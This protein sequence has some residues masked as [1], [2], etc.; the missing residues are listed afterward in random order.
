MTLP[1]VWFLFEHGKPV[2]WSSCAETLETTKRD[3]Q[4]M[5]RYSPH[6][7]ERCGVNEVTDQILTPDEI[8]KVMADDKLRIGSRDGI[9]GPGFV[10]VTTALEI[11]G[12]RTEA[13]LDLKRGTREALTTL[14]RD[15]ETLHRELSRLREGIGDLLSRNGCDCECDHDCESHDSDCDR[16]LACRVQAV[17]TGGGK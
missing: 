16:C 3:G 8:R 2:V 13:Y 7:P 11:L 9:A 14:E 10:S 6:D 5:V 17:L 12:R 15:R 4:W 1:D